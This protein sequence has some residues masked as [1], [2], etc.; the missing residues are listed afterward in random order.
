MFALCA[1]SLY[2]ASAWAD[3]VHVVEQREVGGVTTVMRDETKIT[4]MPWATAPAPSVDGAIF[5]HWTISTQQDFAAR[6]AWERAYDAP[7]FKLYEDTTLTAHYLPATR[8]T[9]GVGVT[10]AF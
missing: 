7:R 8:D 2:T 5:T 10:V 3:L 4:G 9:D 1:V 6:D